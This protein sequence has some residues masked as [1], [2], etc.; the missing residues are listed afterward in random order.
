MHVRRGTETCRS[1]HLLFYNYIY[2][3]YTPYNKW[4]NDL[5][6]H[7][8]RIILCIGTHNNVRNNRGTF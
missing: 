5:L 7:Y 1:D 2:I 3:Y 8:I 6:Y 4:I